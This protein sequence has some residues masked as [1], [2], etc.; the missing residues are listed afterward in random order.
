MI[1]KEQFIYSGIP[2]FMGSDYVTNITNL[3]NYD[4]AFIG[5]PSDYGA[6][7]RLGSKYAVRKIREYSFWDRIEDKE[8]HMA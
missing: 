8:I 2:T 5:V 4:V 7:Y 3:S 6:S 1:N